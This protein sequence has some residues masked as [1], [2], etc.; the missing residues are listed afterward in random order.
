VLLL[1]SAGG[2]EGEASTRSEVSARSRGT[3]TTVKRE[4]TCRV[5]AKVLMRSCCSIEPI[6][7]CAVACG[8]D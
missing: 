2:A 3:D 4:T 6:Q 7:L 1:R 8:L 5:G